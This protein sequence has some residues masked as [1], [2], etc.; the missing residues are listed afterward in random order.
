MSFS[1]VPA[2]TL[3]SPPH[4]PAGSPNLNHVQVAPNILSPSPPSPEPLSFLPVV[5]SLYTQRNWYTITQETE[6]HTSRF[7]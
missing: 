1:Y 2:L 4:L 5:V 3:V 7:P 6:K